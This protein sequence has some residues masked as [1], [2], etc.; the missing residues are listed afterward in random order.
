MQEPLIELSKEK[1]QALQ[2]HLANYRREFLSRMLSSVPISGKPDNVARRKK[3]DDVA[4]GATQLRRVDGASTTPVTLTELQARTLHNHKAKADLESAFKKGGGGLMSEINAEG[5]T[6][7][8][9]AGRISGYTQHSLLEMAGNKIKFNENE[10]NGEAFLNLLPEGTTWNASQKITIGIVIADISE[11]IA[12]E[13]MPGGKAYEDLKEELGGGIE[14][15][16]KYI[17]ARPVVD[18][19]TAAIN[20][21]N[22]QNVSVFEGETCMFT[23]AFGAILENQLRQEQGLATK[24]VKAEMATPARDS[25]AAQAE[26]DADIHTTCKTYAEESARAA[27]AAADKAVFHPENAEAARA[28]AKEVRKALSDSA[29]HQA[30]HAEA[31]E[32]EAAAPAVSMAAVIVATAQAKADT[33]TM[34]KQEKVSQD[35]LR[36][37]VKTRAKA[38]QKGDPSDPS[39]RA[40]NAATKLSTHLMGSIDQ[41]NATLE[42]PSEP[43]LRKLKVRELSQAMREAANAIRALHTASDELNKNANSEP[44]K[45]DIRQANENATAALNKLDTLTQRFQEEAPFIETLNTLRAT[46]N[47]HQDIEQQIGQKI[48]QLEMALS[49]PFKDAVD[50]DAVNASAQRLLESLPVQKK[51]FELSEKLQRKPNWEKDPSIANNVKKLNLAT[52]N[53]RLAIDDPSAAITGNN[54]EEVLQAAKETIKQVENPVRNVIRRAGQTASQMLHAPRRGSSSFFARSASSP[55]QSTVAAQKVQENPDAAGQQPPSVKA[56]LSSVAEEPAEKPVVPPAS[57]DGPKGPG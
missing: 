38:E 34:M 46:T 29:R 7:Q 13:T 30:H 17:S 9:Q 26:E 42:N 51:L 37:E 23:A 21:A 3:L 56:P 8:V 19:M 52:Q 48:A 20:A 14:G 35:A 50:V 43:R 39:F 25:K 40:L 16:T 32:G 12:R 49:L 18:V 6:Y 22:A 5:T 57:N 53:I 54:F 47:Q 31:K 11:H 45:S 36:Q 41:A 24:K 2:N 4:L 1:H 33:N 28:A 55:S 44:L 10:T 15:L 27:E